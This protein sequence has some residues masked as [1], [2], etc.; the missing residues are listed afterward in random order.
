MKAIYSS[1]QYGAVIGV[2]AEWYPIV[3][4]IMTA[5]TSGRDVR[6]TYIIKSAQC[7]R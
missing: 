1:S 6:M 7:R 4:A 5:L 3:L 2:F